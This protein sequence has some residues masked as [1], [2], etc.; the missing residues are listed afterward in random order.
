MPHP[1]LAALSRDALLEMAAAGDEV[2]GWEHILSRSGDSV[3]R[4]VTGGAEPRAWDHYPSGDVYDAD[5]RAQYYFHVHPVAER[6]RGEIGHFHTFLRGPDSP[7]SVSHLVGIGIDREGRVIRLFTTNRW[8][9]GETWRDAADVIA[10]LD[11]F[12]IDHA[13]PSW[14]LNRWVTAVP[15]L[16]RPRIE[17]LLRARDTAIRAWAATG[18]LDTVLEDRA[19]EVTSEARVSVDDQIV[20][21]GDALGR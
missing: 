20:A 13:R 17:A 12:A 14:P 4:E 5:R 9:T 11:H 19:L 1:D 16:F 6:P 15:R 18:S 21:I 7:D 8:V 3:L 2:V 10:M